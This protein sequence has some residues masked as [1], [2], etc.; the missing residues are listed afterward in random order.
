MQRGDRRASQITADSRT[1]EV[2]WDRGVGGVPVGVAGRGGA[3][4][5]CEVGRSGATLEGLLKGRLELHPSKRKERH[6]RTRICRGSIGNSV[7][8]EDIIGLWL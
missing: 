7:G 1:I 8:V 2:R 5:P 6:P 3:H 4:A